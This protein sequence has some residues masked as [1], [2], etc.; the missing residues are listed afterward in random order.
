MKNNIIVI[1]KELK[2]KMLMALKAGEIDTNEFSELSDNKISIGIIDAP[3]NTLRTCRTFAG[4]VSLS[5]NEYINYLESRINEEKRDPKDFIKELTPLQIEENQK[6]NKIIKMLDQQ[7][8]VSI[9]YTEDVKGAAD[10]IEK[11]DNEE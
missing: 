7:S 5:K 4:N 2:I 11:L 10:F 8:D 9:I 1:N 3:H 6:Y